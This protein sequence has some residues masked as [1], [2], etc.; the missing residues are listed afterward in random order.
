MT[1]SKTKLIRKL[2]GLGV[3]V[4]TQYFKPSATELDVFEQLFEKFD[5]DCAEETT[6]TFSTNRIPLKKLG[7]SSIPLKSLNW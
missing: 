1:L 3:S 5:F 6:E 4:S 7:G 2:K